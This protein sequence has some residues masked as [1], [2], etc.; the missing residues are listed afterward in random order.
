M[1]TVKKRK[2]AYVAQVLRHNRYEFLQLIVL[3]KLAGIRAV[4]QKKSWLHSLREGTVI[5][6]ALDFSI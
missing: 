6:S 3:G 5:A 1:Q 2:V 4:G